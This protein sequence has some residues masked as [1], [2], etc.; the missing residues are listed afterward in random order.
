ME[1]WVTAAASL[2][3]ALF[4]AVQIRREIN[5]GKQ[6]RRAVE[7]QISGTAFLLRRQLRS[8]LE[9]EPHRDR[10]VTEWLDQVRQ[11]QSFQAELDTAESRME[12]LARLAPEVGGRISEQVSTAYVFFLA[13]TNRLNIREA[14]RESTGVEVF[15]WLQLITDAAKD[16]RECLSA[17]EGGP[18]SQSLLDADAALRERREREDPF[19]QLAAEMEKEE[20]ISEGGEP[21]SLQDESLREESLRELLLDPPP[22]DPK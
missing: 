20:R 16:L 17:L 15:D 9:I 6:R 5:A 2:A 12:E 1:A 22:G 11:N 21:E 13:A 14:T 3:L 18:I 10:S 19:A 8:W 7:S 4:A